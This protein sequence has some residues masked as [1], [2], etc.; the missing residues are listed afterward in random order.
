[1]PGII[2]PGLTLRRSTRELDLDFDF[3]SQ[4][5]FLSGGHE[6]GSW[7]VGTN[8][9]GKRVVDI[10][11]AEDGLLRYL[12]ANRNEAVQGIKFIQIMIS[13]VQHYHSKISPHCTPE[14]GCLN[15]V[16]VLKYLFSL[17]EK[18]K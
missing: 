16:E 18:E 17:V 8:E 15:L 2:K 14:D 11:D 5:D 10:G 13:A 9:K 3:K 4:I 6:G 12:I 1:M 7:L